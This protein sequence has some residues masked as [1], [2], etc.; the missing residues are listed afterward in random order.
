MKMPFGQIRAFDKAAKDRAEP[1]LSGPAS[2]APPPLPPPPPPPAPG[3]ARTFFYASTL[4]AKGEIG[5]FNMISDVPDAQVSKTD[6]GTQTI[7]GVPAQGTRTTRTIPAGKI[8]NT[9]P[10]VITTETWYSPDLKVLVMSKVN[11]PRMGE[12]TYKLTGLQRADPPAST[13]EIPPDYT[14]KEGGKDI[15]FQVKKP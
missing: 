14:V 1:G 12:T 4:P 3:A 10:I 7:E 15:V 6:L 11:D 13:F 2:D 9:M 8:G 5:V